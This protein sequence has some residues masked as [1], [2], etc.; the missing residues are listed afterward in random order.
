MLTSKQLLDIK[1]LQQACEA[2]ESFELKLNWEMLNERPENETNDFLHYED[3]QL[4]GFIALY[5][6]GNKVELCGMVH[7]E[8]RRKGIFTEL[9]H[10]ALQAVNERGF[11][12]ILLNAPSNS[13][14]AKKFL[15]T[16]PCSY[17]FSEH[18]MKW[19]EKDL[20][21]NEEVKLRLSTPDDFELEVQLNVQCFGFKEDEAREY[22]RRPR[23]DM[24]Q[25][26][27]VMSGEKSVGKMRISR[28]DGE[29]WIYGFAI[30]PEYQGQGIG[31]KALTNAVIK[32]HQTGFPIFLEVEAKNANALRLYESIGFRAYHS[33]D[34]YEK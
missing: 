17:A 5:G 6:F 30:L 25:Y 34:Y 14:S 16:I 29:A 3:G 12:Q 4:V 15:Q 28:T 2:N 7:P 26:Y 8:F 9:Y 31:R 10:T 18:Q 20:S 33:Q 22:N 24:D 32:E 13:Q 11:T 23:W 21:E 19:E 27:I 1:E